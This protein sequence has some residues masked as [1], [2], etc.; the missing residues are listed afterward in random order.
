MRKYLLHFILI[1][2]VLFFISTNLLVVTRGITDVSKEGK[3][4]YLYK[5]YHA[6]VIGISKYDYWP[7]LPNALK[8]AVEVEG[9]LKEMDL[10]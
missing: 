10:M 9:M 5:D 1:S 7:D 2:F 4:V 8:D 6:L 3:S